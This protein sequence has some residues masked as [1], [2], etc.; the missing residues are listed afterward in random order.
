[1]VQIFG[2]KEEVS[3]ISK[4]LSYFF[5]EVENDKWCLLSVMDDD[6]IQEVLTRGMKLQKLSINLSTE[7]LIFLEMDAWSEEAVEH[8]KKYKLLSIDGRKIIIALGPTELNEEVHIHDQKRM[9][10]R[11]FFY[12]AQKYFTP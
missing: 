5:Y 4:G 8:L 9:H 3:S 2:L 1:M 10:I 11:N 12:Q 7:D 6:A